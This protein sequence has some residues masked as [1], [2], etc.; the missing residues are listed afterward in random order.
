MYCKNCGNKLEEG[1]KFCS[2]CGYSVEVD[3]NNNMNLK[4][5]IMDIN[6]K[7]LKL[8]KFI[9]IFLFILST[10]LFIICVMQG[11]KSAAII[12]LAST[13]FFAHLYD[14]SKKKKS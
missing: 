14:K 5:N 8:E 12:C 11:N 13:I 3:N 7:K 9:L 10:I 6:E 1:S 4:E 2:N